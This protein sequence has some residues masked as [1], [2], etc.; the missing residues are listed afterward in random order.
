MY[1]WRVLLCVRHHARSKFFKLCTHN[2]TKPH[3]LHRRLIGADAHQ[4]AQLGPRQG[5]RARLKLHLSFGVSCVVRRCLGPLRTHT[6]TTSN[7]ALLLF[8]LLITMKFN[9]DNILC[10]HT[11]F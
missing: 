6:H 5:L 8:M 11:V 1:R 3:R 7:H 4:L 9:Q 2:N 10:V